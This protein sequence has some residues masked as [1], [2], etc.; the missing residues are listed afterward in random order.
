MIAP[1]DTFQGM[2]CT[3]CTTYDCNLRCVYCYEICKHKS[4]IT[5]DKVY[6][7]IDR[8]IEDDDPIG[9]T[10]TRDA[11]ISKTGMVMDFIG[12]DSFMQPEIIDK[13]VT[14]LQYKLVMTD[15]P[16]KNN[17]RASISSNGTLFANPEVQKVIE[18]NTES[19]FKTFG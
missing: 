18:K 14:Y 10:G 11:W 5:M 4:E 15:H 8:L 7:F 13:A 1:S 16:W 2:N 9:A 6:K 3:V 12:G 19:S 17:W